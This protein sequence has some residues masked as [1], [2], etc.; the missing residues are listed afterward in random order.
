MPPLLW[1]VAVW[2]VMEKVG[3]EAEGVHEKTKMEN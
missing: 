1:S 3:K 2:S